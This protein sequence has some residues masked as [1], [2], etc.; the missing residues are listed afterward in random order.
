MQTIITAS[1]LAHAGAF[2]REMVVVDA[3]GVVA[4]GYSSEVNVR[5]LG[6]LLAALIMLSAI[7]RSQEHQFVPR[8]TIPTPAVNIP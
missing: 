4:R 8:P 1:N 7:A 3:W 2:T 5:Q 6:I